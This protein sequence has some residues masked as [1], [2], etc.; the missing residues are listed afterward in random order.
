MKDKISVIVP[1]YNVEDYLPKCIESIMKQTYKNLE[2]ILVDDGSKD[3][4]SKI[5]DEFKLK[6]DRIV[7]IHKENG[8]LSEARNSGMKAATGQYIAFIDSDDYIREDM[9]EILL[10]RIIRD[11]S[12]MAFCNFLYVNEQGEIIPER[13]EYYP[14]VDG[15]FSAGEIYNQTAQEHF[16]PYTAS[17]N[18][19]YKSYL[20]KEIY[21]P[22]GKTVEDAFIAH[23]IVGRCQRISGVSLPLYYY[24]QRNNSIMNK[25]FN[26]SRLDGVEAFGQRAI[27]AMEHDALSL[28]VFSVR[29]MIAWM[30]KGLR[31]IEN[32]ELFNHRYLEL[33]KLYDN[34]Y[35]KIIKYPI[36]MKCRIQFLLFKISPTVYNFLASIL[37]K[38]LRKS[39]YDAV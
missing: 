3:G 30:I 38:I 25:S 35:R 12:D 11:S 16:A 27:Y 21:F 7:V 17:T 6:D 2:I 1:V 39:F 22:V 34:V 37:E 18:K 19:L 24:V 10:D 5:C 8:G 15:V 14:V 20:L 4:S 23:I 26:I 31:S 32:S 29:L 13:N 28:G 36:G 9:L 33:K